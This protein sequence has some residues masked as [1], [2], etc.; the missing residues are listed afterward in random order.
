MEI[1]GEN[2][3]PVGRMGLFARFPFLKHRVQNMDHLIRNCDKFMDMY[4]CLLEC[5]PEEACYL[6]DTFD[7]IRISTADILRLG[8]N[9]ESSDYVDHPLDSIALGVLESRSF[10]FRLVEKIT[11]I[12]FV[13]LSYSVVKSD[14]SLK[15]WPTLA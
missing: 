6:V 7:Y 4:T 9:I 15:F 8:E 13:K 1:E 14:C 12:Q 5:F 3:V 11:C 10:L 2:R